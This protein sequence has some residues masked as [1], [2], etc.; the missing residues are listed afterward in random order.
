MASRSARIL[1]LVTGQ[2]IPDLAA[3]RGDYPAWI[4]E[5]A[6]DAWAGRTVTWSTHD[7]RTAA[8][9]PGRRDA[10]AFVLTGS[11][12][13]VTERAPWMLRCEALVRD[14]AAAGRPVLG[15]C[16]GHQLIAQ[17]LGGL[18]TKNPRG[19]EIGT[20]RVQRVADDPLFAGLPR[21]FDIHGTHVD[22]VAKLPPG[23]EVLATTPKDP[24]AAFRVGRSVRGVQFHPEFDADVMR[25][26]L[27]AR[28][29]VVRAEGG[30]PEALLAQVHLP[31]RGE[32]LL[33]N[34][35]KGIL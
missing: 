9:L 12:S 23:G 3:R 25:G 26:Y 5:K 6:G 11:S 34:F 7:V 35:V 4:R 24:I 18:V 20:M 32:T 27:Q 1:V 21:A 31:T 17:A 29:E 13:S 8:P 19:R 28:A 15:I 16:F 30:D 10:D 22:A 2:T 14:I 33:R